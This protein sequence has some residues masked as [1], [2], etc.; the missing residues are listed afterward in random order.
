LALAKNLSSKISFLLGRESEHALILNFADHQI[1]AHKIDAILP[2]QES[3]YT[4][5]WFDFPEHPINRFIARL[6]SKKFLLEI[7]VKQDLKTLGIEHQSFSLKDPSN[8]LLEFKYTR[9]ASAIF[10][11]KDFKKNWRGK[12]K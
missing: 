1:V 8:N 5:F 6:R 11:K 7:P 3:I 4:T 10:V 12:L 9:Y 2:P